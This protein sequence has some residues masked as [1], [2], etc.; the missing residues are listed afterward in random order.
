MMV[1]RSELKARRKKFGDIPFPLNGRR[2]QYNPRH[3]YGESKYV[4]VLSI[5]HD[6]Q[7]NESWALAVKMETKTSNNL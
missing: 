2:R 3:K 7:R 6:D 4:C 1:L 5:L